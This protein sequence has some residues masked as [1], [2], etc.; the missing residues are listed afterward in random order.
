MLRLFYDLLGAGGLF[1]IGYIAWN[2]RRD[3]PP[4]ARQFTLLAAAAGAALGLDETFSLHERLGTF[5]YERG[6][7]EPAGINHFDDLIVIGI[8]LAG[9]ITAGFF[10]NEVLRDAVFA[11]LFGLAVCLLG[12]AIA[13]DTAFDPTRTINWWTEETLE[14]AGVS[15]MALAFRLR[16]MRL[17]GWPVGTTSDV[18]SVLSGS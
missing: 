11:R 10:V 1:F 6:W 16:A 18:P 5:L 12:L 15:V 17:A 9:L 14:L 7:R 13:W 2:G 3:G 4:L 8:G